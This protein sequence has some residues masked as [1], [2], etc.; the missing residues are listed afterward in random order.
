MRVF[1]IGD[2]RTGSGP[3]NVTKE[4]LLRLPKDTKRLIFSSKIMRALE[5]IFKMPF[6]DVALFSGYSGQNIL[7]LKWA[8][9][10]KK[11]GVYLMHGCVEHE[12]AINE[13]IS[14]KMNETERKTMELSTAIFAVSAR[15]ASW[16]KTY[17]PEYAD[18]IDTALNGVDT[19]ALALIRKQGGFGRRKDGMI[20]TVGGGM[21]RK[22]IKHI[23]GAIEILNRMAGT[24][25]YTL[26]VVGEPGHDDEKIASYPFVR[27]LGHVRASEVRKLYREASLFVQNSCFET[28]GLA[29]MEALMNGCSV[30]MSHEVGALEL[31]YDVN[32]GDIINNWYDETEIAGKIEALNARGNA[33]R[34]LKAL[35]SRSISWDAR[36]MEL[37]NKLV[38][39]QEKQR[40]AGEV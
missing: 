8:K 11:P 25:K 30:L 21:P 33:A 5:I 12:N 9:R 7:G 14:A 37:W 31:F 17:Y 2:Y 1:V 4:Y 3:A 19:G 26:T 6:C 39:I 34:L 13:C 18:K 16:L 29:P 28:F 40:T 32:D 27:N 20:L 36:T 15:F 23:C 22:K 35:D 24:E 38:L 10:L